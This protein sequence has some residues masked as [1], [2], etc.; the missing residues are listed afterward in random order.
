MKKFFRLTFITI[1]ILSFAII[2]CSANSD[3]RQKYV[4]YRKVKIYTEAYNYSP[5]KKEAIIFLHGMGGTHSHGKFLYN[6]SNP[7]M[8]I[9]LDYLDHGNSG[10]IPVVSWKTQL[11]SIKEVLDSYGIKKAH[12]VG[13]SFGAD[14]A[15]MFAKKYPDRVKDIVLLDRA[16][17]NFKDL[18][19]F[20]MTKNLSAVLEYDPESGLSKDEQ[21]Q[22][23][24]MSWDSDITRT[25]NI[26]KNVLLISAD[27]KNF[28][29]DP[30]T[31]TP[32]LAEIVSM[33]KENPLEF[34]IDP[35]EAELLPDITENNI[36]DLVDFLKTKAD[37]FAHVNN[38]FS[39]VHTSYTHGEMVRDSNAMNEMRTYVIDYLQSKNNPIKDCK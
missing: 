31:G 20:N 13:H 27:T 9:T 16:Y 21:L 12:L 19:Q 38:R 5:N 4:R 26:T 34:G 3:I 6:Q 10:H 36:L 11:D 1:L 29:G 18:E 25:W 37:K 28:T 30:S 24:N 23:I 32:S 17:Y 2:P 14:T 15:M 33:I 22:Y 7:Y 8:T 35:A 39:V